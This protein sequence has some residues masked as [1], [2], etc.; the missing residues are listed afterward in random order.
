MFCIEESDMDVQ[1]PEV[2]ILRD[3]TPIGMKSM[4]NHYWYLL[5]IT[6]QVNIFYHPKNIMIHFTP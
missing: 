3:T 1:A 2:V 4:N 5:N 6:D